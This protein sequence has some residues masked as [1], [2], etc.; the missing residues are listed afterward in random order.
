MEKLTEIRMN[1][2][3][4]ELYRAAEL[5]TTPRK[6]TLNNKL[7]ALL[8][9]GFVRTGGAYLLKTQA[10]FS[11]TPTTSFQDLT[12]YE[13]FVN[14]IHIDDYLTDMDTDPNQLINLEQGIAFARR[15]VEE[16]ASSFLQE[17]FTIIVAYGQ[18]GCSVRFHLMRSGE[19]WI[20]DNLDDYEEEALLVL[21]TLPH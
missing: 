1:S 11:K 6:Q 14:H 8:N 15:I 3:M 10:K 9:S 4:Q 12:G 18:S 2:R 17:R 20:S 21:E 5:A 16:L 19:R 7:A 13:C